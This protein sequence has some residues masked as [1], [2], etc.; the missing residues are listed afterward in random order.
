[1]TEQT[2]TN[3]SV[4]RVAIEAA[5]KYAGFSTIG[6]CRSQKGFEY[7]RSGATKISRP[8]TYFNAYGLT[9]EARIPFLQELASKGFDISDILKMLGVD[10]S[11]I[12][13]GLTLDKKVEDIEVNLENG[14]DI[15]LLG[16]HDGFEIQKGRF[17][18][19]VNPKT[20][21][22]SFISVKNHECHR[23]LAATYIPTN[24]IVEAGFIETSIYGQNIIFTDGSESFH[25]G[26]GELSMILLN[27]ALPGWIIR[28]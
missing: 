22:F 27:R 12:K 14:D 4:D 3:E 9:Q 1:M 5:R 19:G 26:P 8:E 2:Q 28:R 13:T 25:Q 6:Y 15:K 7:G 23:G 17:V 18:T 20:G 16:Y 11:N 21:R 10:S 24:E